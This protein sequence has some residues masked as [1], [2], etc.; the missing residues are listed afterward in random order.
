MA[1]TPKVN[2]AAV[3]AGMSSFDFSDP[4]R[5]DPLP[6]PND[7]AATGAADGL[8]PNVNA[9]PDEAAVLGAEPDVPKEKGDGE[10][11]PVRGDGRRARFLFLLINGVLHLLL[12][13]LVLFREIRAPEVDVFQRIFLGRLGFR[14][15]VGIV[16]FE[17][18]RV[19]MGSRFCMPRSLPL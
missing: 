9:D 8:V 5:E 1:E 19:D 16:C 18:G 17:G 4:S 12:M 14:A 7:G 10:A 11:E 6:N 15:L 3:D 13:L 2:G